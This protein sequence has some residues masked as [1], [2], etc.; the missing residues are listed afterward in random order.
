MREEPRAVTTTGA[1]AEEPPMEDYDPL[2]V[3]Q[4]TQRL[5]ELSVEEI[6]RL[7]EYEAKNRNR[8]SLMQRFD[9]RRAKLRAYT[10]GA[11]RTKP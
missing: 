5:G 10:S 7:R 2:N 9:T 6:K 11:V 4:V 1:E 3:H 8:R